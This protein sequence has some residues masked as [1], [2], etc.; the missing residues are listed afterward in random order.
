MRF[1]SNYELEQ[2]YVGQIVL[3]EIA[4]KT[5]DYI[6]QVVADKE[7][8]FNNIFGN[9]LRIKIPFKPLEEY[10]EYQDLLKIAS[11]VKG[12][13]SID[14]KR[15][16]IVR[17]I[18]LNPEYGMGEEKKQYI[19]IGKILAASKLP[20]ERRKHIL[21]WFAYFAPTLSESKDYSIVISRSPIDILRM[22]EIGTTGHCHEQG[23]SYFHCAIQEAKNGG[24]I[25]FVVKTTELNNYSEESFQYDEFFKDKERDVYGTYA[26]S[27][28]RIRRIA[29]ESNLNV[30]F[31]VPETSVYGEQFGGFYESVKE[32]LMKKQE[33]NFDL[34]QFIKDI[35]NGE[36]VYTGGSYTDTDLNRLLNKMFDFKFKSQID[37]YKEDALE[38]PDN[39]EHMDIPPSEDDLIREMEDRLNAYENNYDFDYF[40][41]SFYVDS[42]MEDNRNFDIYYGYSAILSIDLT[43]L[44]LDI[45][46]TIDIN[47]DE[48]DIGILEDYD[49]NS[50]E[51]YN[52]R[53]PRGI[54][55]ELGL[56][57]QQF[58]KILKIS[59]KSGFVKSDLIKEITLV[60]NYNRSNLTFVCKAEEEISY[61]ATDY[62]VFL[63]DLS[64]YDHYNEHEK[65][66]NGIKVALAKSG[67]SKIDIPYASEEELEQE[68]KYSELDSDK[69][70]IKFDQFSIILTHDALE[71]YFLPKLGK[72]EVIEKHLKAANINFELDYSYKISVLL[73]K[74]IDEH[75]KP[76][77]DDDNQM[78]F[79]SFYEAF[80]N[81]DLRDYDITLLTTSTQY[82][83]HVFETLFNVNIKYDGFLTKPL[84]E[85]LL[86]LDDSV[87]V[88]K[89]MVEYIYYYYCLEYRNHYVDNLHRIYGKW[90]E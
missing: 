51:V 14:L 48:H 27:R 18:K 60:N 34:D 53:L 75:F 5:V 39:Y 47:L 83:G 68:L 10:S 70:E 50:K 79:K 24:P 43:E 64:E 74:Y 9:K 88:I 12:F 85:L 25:A 32:F 81:N 2:I 13:D 54:D 22:G 46:Y 29:K 31:A 23:G 17:K 37:H 16:E 58:F 33:S 84:K 40:R 71:K 28:L 65:L 45:N 6:K 21:D 49:P 38:E 66:L 36:Y 62:D 89:Q 20:E 78:T 72:P 63:R 7:L 41:P 8:P 56:K 59:D 86:F 69:N 80:F 73:K 35:E 19:G 1:K 15:K 11:S 57:L 30:N 44:N 82:M 61:D 52:S 3:N 55:S 67:L 90:L 76:S 4:K 42:H 26:I 87:D 77:T